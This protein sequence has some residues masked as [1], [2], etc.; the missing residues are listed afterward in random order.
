VWPGRFAGDDLASFFAGLDLMPPGIKEG[1]V[2]GGTGFKALAAEA[3]GA[4]GVT[5][6]PW[7]R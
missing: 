2:V 5:G 3:T 6:T 7:R 1:G 4:A